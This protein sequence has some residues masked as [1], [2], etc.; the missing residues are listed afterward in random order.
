MSKLANKVTCGLLL[1][2]HSTNVVGSLLNNDR[3]NEF[4]LL[5]IIILG[6][7]FNVNIG[8]QML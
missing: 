4:K 1:S 2:S 6:T 3:R 5:A 8:T 7:F